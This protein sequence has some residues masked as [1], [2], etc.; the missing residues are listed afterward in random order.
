MLS[1]LL[2]KSQL[3]QV[4][5]MPR[6]AKYYFSSAASSARA[7]LLIETSEVQDLI[8]AKDPNVRFINASWYMPGSK[9]DAK[10][11]HEEHRLTKETQYFS[12]AEIV[13]PD[14]KLP[15]TMP[16][17]KVFTEHMKAMRI[18]KNHQ[19]VCY[20]HPGLF[21]VARCAMMLRY[22][23]A[24]DVR[25]MNGGL[26]KWLKEG[27][28]VYSGAY[29][30]GMGLSEEG[31]Y[32]Y[33][34]VD[35]S[36]VITDITKVHDIARSIAQGSKDWQITDARAAARFY[37]EMEEPRGMRAGNITGSINVP[38]S[39]LID[40]ETGCLK[41]DAELRQVFDQSGVDLNKQTVHSC[42][43]GVTACIVQLA[44]EVCEG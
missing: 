23:G 29:T 42:G 41:S 26:Q 8:E 15:N 30:S 16:D 21:S 17:A 13:K 32:S 38:Y 44:H 31:D 24:F 2:R 10:V 3:H 43:S 34:A 39:S 36:A 5:P 19:I 35:E 28:P 25:I 27:R 40:A 11:Q 18:G 37:G 12:I 33:E 14:S 4:S 9:I 22:F 7:R 20:D 6:Y 1:S